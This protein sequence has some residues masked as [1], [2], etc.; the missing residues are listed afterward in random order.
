VLLSAPAEVML[1]RIQ[2]RADNPYGK[3]PAETAEID[4]SAP[5]DEVVG[6]LVVTRVIPP[7]RSG[8]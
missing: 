8:R 1:A 2:E 7:S 6:E 5:V 3:D 4:A